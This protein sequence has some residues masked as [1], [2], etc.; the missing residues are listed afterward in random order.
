MPSLGKPKSEPIVFART[1]YTWP[2]TGSSKK[3]KS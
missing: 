1:K 2:S 3:K